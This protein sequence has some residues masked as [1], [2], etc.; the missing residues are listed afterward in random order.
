[1][2]WGT[3]KIS[4]LYLNGCVFAFYKEERSKHNLSVV[5]AAKKILGLFL[6]VLLLSGGLNSFGQTT[7]TQTFSADGSFTVPAG[8]DSIKIE[9]WGSGGNG[10]A[11]VDNKNGGGGGGGGAYVTH[12]NLP[13][14]ENT[15]YTIGIGNNGTS[16]TINTNLFVAGGGSNGSGMSGGSGGTTIAF[17]TIPSGGSSETGSPGSDNKNKTGGAG[18]GAGG[19]GGVGGDGGTNGNPGV[20]GTPP[21]GGGGGG[22]AIN[23]AGG[24]GADGQVIISWACDLGTV[25]TSGA[26][27]ICSNTAPI[28][29][30]TSGAEGSNSF[31][32][33]WYLR[34][35]FVIP[36]SGSTSG[37]ALISGETGTSLTTS[38]IT[39]NT[40][41]AC[42]VMPGGVFQC[43]SAN[44]A[45]ATNTDNVWIT[46]NPLPTATI[47]STNSPICAEE[48]AVF[49]LTG[50]SGAIV[51]YNINS[52]TNT[53][54]TLTG[55]TATVTISGAA[56]QQT[57]TLVSEADANCS[58][59]LSESTTI[60]VNPL[61]D[62][63][64]I[65][66]DN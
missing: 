53:T 65:I 55:G 21:G 8:V 66:T 57:L 24:G 5:F 54:V 13:T 48:D 25:T 59:T 49:T 1:M 38:A 15:V 35:G 32:Y 43:S 6:F 22:G 45:G 62:T 41:Y 52:G 10:A 2:N 12:P 64:E 14:S 16:T 36:T 47:S 63:G 58:Q 33:Q 3:N 20:D 4:N 34:A 27:V 61:P 31:S 60:T 50:T 29:I 17:P 9:A 42:W 40:T 30:S 46:V 51:T 39:A 18:G 37:W 7:T 11:G 23:E 26:T 28:G 56:V 44:W 19:S